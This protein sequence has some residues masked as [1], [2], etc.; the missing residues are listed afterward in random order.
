[1]PRIRMVGES[2]DVAMKLQSS[3][4]KYVWMCVLR[5]TSLV[6]DWLTLTMT[7]AASSG[8]TGLNSSRLLILCLLSMY[9]RM[10][11]L[12]SW[13]IFT[14]WK[15]YENCGGLLAGVCIIFHPRFALVGLLHP[16]ADAYYLLSSKV[17][18]NNC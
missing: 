18:P 6:T 4:P 12:R 2:W 7:P 9:R 13:A 16:L 17:L 10:S 15:T 14:P 1:M 3:G 11:V 5:C 8:P